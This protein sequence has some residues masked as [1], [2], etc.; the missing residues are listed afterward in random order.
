MSVGVKKGR[1]GSEAA[2]LFTRPRVFELHAFAQLV[3][4]LRFFSSLFTRAIGFS[5]VFAVGLSFMDFILA[6]VSEPVELVRPPDSVI[7]HSYSAYRIPIK[8]KGGGERSVKRLNNSV[9]DEGVGGRGVIYKLASK[10]I[11]FTRASTT[12][13]IA[14]GK[15]M[16]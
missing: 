7:Y 2:L 8:K 14:A 6:F 5:K 3:S 13:F 9:R 16:R 12:S 15:G 4:V 1:R 10:Q 11:C